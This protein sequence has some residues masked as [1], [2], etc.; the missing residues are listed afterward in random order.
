MTSDKEARASRRLRAA[1][2]KTR[3][4]FGGVVKDGD[5]WLLRLEFVNENYA[6]AFGRDLEALL[7]PGKTQDTPADEEE[8]S[9]KISQPKAGI[10]MY[11]SDIVVHGPC[12][13]CG[14][15]QQHKLVTDGYR[16]WD[17]CPACPLS[18]LV[19]LSRLDRTETGLVL[20][21]G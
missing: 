7:L 10:T 4:K 19:D 16:F 13:Q 11:Y 15:D 14:A 2:H 8:L 20:N 1:Y 5:V 3:P 12:S 18:L 17:N 21:K 6:G 9:S